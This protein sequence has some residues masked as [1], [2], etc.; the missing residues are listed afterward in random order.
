MPSKGCPERLAVPLGNDVDSVRVERRHQDED[1][2]LAGS[3][4]TCGLSSV[5]SL[6]ANSIAVCVDATSVEWIEQVI[7]TTVLPCG[8][9]FSAW[10]SVVVSGSASRSWM[11][12]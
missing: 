3:F 5:R 8:I 10:A 2:V 9:S 6:Y 1:R 12:R 4:E 7:S 11:S